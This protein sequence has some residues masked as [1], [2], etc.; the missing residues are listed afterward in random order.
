MLLHC[1]VFCMVC[2]L[3]YLHK[4]LYHNLKNTFFH[5]LWLCWYVILVKYSTLILYLIFVFNAALSFFFINEICLKSSRPLWKHSSQGICFSRPSV[6][7]PPA[8][9]KF[10]SAGFDFLLVCMIKCSSATLLSTFASSL[11][12]IISEKQRLQLS[13]CKK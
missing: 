13:W 2:V 11:F 7:G 3:H 12:T 10:I 8:P 1:I 6:L 4:L 5:F 9:I